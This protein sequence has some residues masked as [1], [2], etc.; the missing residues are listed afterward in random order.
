M[1]QLGSSAVREGF[2]PL[3]AQLLG[4]S[5][6]AAVQQANATLTLTTE[7]KLKAAA[8]SFGCQ[9]VKMDNLASGVSLIH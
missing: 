4:L 3:A 7:E 9:E 8:I 6:P 1:G 5:L 2:V